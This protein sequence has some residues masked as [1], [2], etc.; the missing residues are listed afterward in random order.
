MCNLY[1]NVKV[2]LKS[3]W[4]LQNWFNISNQIIICCIVN[5]SNY[6]WFLPVFGIL[7]VFMMYFVG[8]YIFFIIILLK[9]HILKNIIKFVIHCINMY[10]FFAKQ[11]FFYY[12]IMHTKKRK[13]W[14]EY[15]VDIYFVCVCV[16]L[17]SLLYCI[18]I[19]FL[20]SFTV[21]YYLI[22]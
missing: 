11:H 3:R 13:R 20:Y 5:Q 4:E 1:N 6:D 16:C 2:L 10:F 7:L 15:F 12:N 8:E 18:I 22:E 17:L 19:F 9:I 14:Y 21:N